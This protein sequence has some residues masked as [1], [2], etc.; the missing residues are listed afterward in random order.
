MAEEYM[1][2]FSHNKYTRPGGLV[3]ALEW[4]SSVAP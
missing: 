3:V 4:H 1:D 2:E